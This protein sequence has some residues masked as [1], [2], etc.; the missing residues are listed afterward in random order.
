MLAVGMP[1]N[2]SLSTIYSAYLTRHFGKFKASILEQVQIII[3]AT[4]TLHS[5]VTRSFRKTA[6]N[7]HYEFNVRHLTNVF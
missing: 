6:A 5:D 1:E 4:L 3:K 7:F 2:A